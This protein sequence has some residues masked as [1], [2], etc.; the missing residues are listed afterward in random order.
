MKKITGYIDRVTDVFC[1]SLMSVAFL[2]TFFHIIGRYV[3][4]NPIYFSEE[5]A[6]YCFI[7]ASMLGAAV[8]NRHD[9]HT[10]VTYFINLLPPRVQDVIYILRELLIVVILC[11]LI[12]QGIRL[13]YTMRT[14][15]TA[16]LALSWALVYIS[17]PIG[18][19]LMI[20]STLHL[21]KEKI[22]E[23]LNPERG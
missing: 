18:S 20:I 12:F 22:G 6:R 2:I 10:S 16:A 21:I 13:S 11:V 23:M 1:I 8:V 15:Q 17:L 5:L 3:L 9:E 4:R 19:A 14:V 7:W